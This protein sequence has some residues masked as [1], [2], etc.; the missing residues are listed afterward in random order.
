MPGLGGRSR[1]PGVGPGLW[2]PVGFRRTG[3]AGLWIPSSAVSDTERVPPSF[4]I[5]RIGFSDLFDGTPQWQDVVDRL[6]RYTLEQVLDVVGRASA[7]LNRFEPWKS[8]RG[9]R[10]LCDSLFGGGSGRVRDAVAR[11]VRS[12][13]RDERPRSFVLFHELQLINLAKI[14]L[15]TLTADS[16]SADEDLTCLGE[17][18]LMTNDLITDEE[19]AITREEAATLEGRQR[20]QRYVVMNGLFHHGGNDLHRLVRANELYLTDRSHL[21]SCGSYLDLPSLMQEVTGI[22]A[23]ALWTILFAMD[24]HWRNVKPEEGRVP[25][26]LNYNTYFTRHCNFTED[27]SRLLFSLVADDAETTRQKLET[28]AYGP[29]S[30]KPYDVLPFEDKPLIVSGDWVYCASVQLLFRKMTRGLHHLFLNGLADEARRDQYLTYMGEVFGDYVDSLFARAFLPETGRCIDG[31]SLKA[32]AP[33][34]VKVCDDAL[35][36]GDAVILIESKATLFTLAV[37]TAGNWEEY[38]RKVNDIFVDAAAQL[39]ATV[40]QIEMGTYRDLGL[41]PN[42]I[43][44]YFPVVVTLE[45]LPMNRLIYEDIAARIRDEGHLQHA[46]VRPFQ[47]VDASDLEFLEVAVNQGRSLR[48][49]L[50]DKLSTAA[51]RNESMGNYCIARDESFIREENAYLKARF[52]ELAERAEAFIRSRSRNAETAETHDT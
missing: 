35:L 25:G 42:S 36:Y 29:G 26:P 33:A 52:R 49:L 51:A 2:V 6:R 12:L 18:L 45:D 24:G 21:L 10:L 28:G 34:G 22:S 3:A 41:E 39:D 31:A 13:P 8:R 7:L 43:H 37:R 50:D 9:Q 1:G 15:L 40:R 32:L 47:G 17:A 44:A 11:W 23:D 30:L 20:F 27:E 46:K 38:Q 4:L 14:A 5:I 16:G 48:E 19:P